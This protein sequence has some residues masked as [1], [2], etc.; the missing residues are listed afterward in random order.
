MDILSSGIK[1]VQ[2]RRRFAPPF[3][4]SRLCSP[5]FADSRLCSP[6]EKRP[7]E[8]KVVRRM[9][10]KNLIY[11]QGMALVVFSLACAPCMSKYVYKSSYECVD[12]RPNG[13][14]VVWIYSVVCLLIHVLLFSWSMCRPKKWLLEAWLLETC[15][16]FWPTRCRQV[17]FYRFSSRQ[18]VLV[19]NVRR[20]LSS[21]MH[22]IAIPIQVLCDLIYSIDFNGALV[23]KHE[24]PIDGHFNKIVIHWKT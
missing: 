17:P 5:P 14:L 24:L 6:T 4:D 13:Q 21:F 11:V 22:G 19:L 18:G 3:A 20:L 23:I 16:I 8:I 15:A 12:A 9:L 10:L 2:S 1:P 7:S